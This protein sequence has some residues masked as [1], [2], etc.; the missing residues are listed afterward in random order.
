MTA[1]NDL[2]RMLGAWFAAEAAPAPPADPLTRIL[3]TTRRR[4]PRPSL[5]AGIASGWIGGGPQRIYG[6]ARLRPALIFALVALIALGVAVAALVGSRLLAPQPW[7]IRHTYVNE[8]VQGADLPTP[9]AHPVLVALVDGQVLVIGGDGDGGSQLTTALVYDPE[10]GAS[11]IAGPILSPERFVS[12]AVQLRDGRVLLIGDTVVQLFDP[13]TLQFAS[14]GSM[15]VPRVGGEVA[16]LANGR[17]LMAG[18]NTP[19]QQSALRSAELFDP[20]TLTFARTGSFVAAGSAGPLVALP[21]GRVF[22]ASSPTAEIYDPRSGTF[23]VAGSMPFSAKRAVA[24]PDG[25]VV[26]L[27]LSGLQTAG[28]AAVWDPTSQTFSSVFDGPNP[29]FDATLLDDGRILMNGGRYASWSSVLDPTTGVTTPTKATRA[30]R[31]TLLRLI[32]GRVLVVGGLVDG[33]V[34]PTGGGSMAPALTTVEIY[35]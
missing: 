27:G 12:S 6:T 20:D 7:P 24:L 13:T 15:V 17:V 19:D 1:R 22:M 29:V 34:R 10:T 14:A 25:R 8:F 2:D 26:V 23:A 3:D 18:G 32:D 9:M 11:V 31:P 16:L 5:V 33:R 4:R 21:D 28:H 30:W 35:Q